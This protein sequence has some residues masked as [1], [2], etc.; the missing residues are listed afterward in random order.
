[1]I[2]IKETSRFELEIKKSRF[3]SICSRVDSVE[4]ANNFFNENSVSEAT[5]NCWAYKI[6]SV[7]RF[8]DDNEPGGTAGRPILSA[9]E[10]QEL[11]HTA[12]LVIRFF[13]GIKLGAGGLVRAYSQAAAGSL[14]TAFKEEIFKQAS[15]CFEVPFNMTGL[16]Y[17]MIDTFSCLKD[18]EQYG[19]TGLLFSLRLNENSVEDFKT[20]LVNA[21]S[22]K[23][24]FLNVP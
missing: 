21:T 17:N 18:D 19:N 14:K 20:E 8:N 2:T 12:V 16:V 15:I 22:G 3:I 1:L 23:T 9:I 10:G 6:D 4:D 24:V 5:H 13:G 11:D 7:Y